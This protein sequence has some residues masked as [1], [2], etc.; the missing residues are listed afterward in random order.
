MPSARGKTTGP[1]RTVHFAI[2]TAASLAASFPLPAYAEPVSAAVIPM[3]D[4]WQSFIDEAAVR[5]G[6]PASWIRAVIRVESKGD[7]QA[8]SPNGAIGLMQLMPHTYA[9]LCVRFGLGD[10]PTDPHDNIVAG[11]AYLRELYERFGF[12]GF[13][14]AYNAGPRRYEDHLVTGRSLPEETLAYVAELAPML[15]DGVSD[16]DPVVADKRMSWR[17]SSLF[18]AQSSN[19]SITS[20]SPFTPQTEI[21]HSGRAVADLS[22]LVPLSGGL[23]VRKPKLASRRK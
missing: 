14:A 11:T 8:V 18:V 7:P 17:Q 16:G 2:I 20:R 13:V 22:A 12:A 23:F 9:Q 10:D 19:Q 15:V 21:A 6:I 4:P 3:A 1:H 5:F